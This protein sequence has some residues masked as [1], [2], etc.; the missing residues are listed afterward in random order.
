MRH[1]SVVILCEVTSLQMVCLFR[2]WIVGVLVEEMKKAVE[3]T[4]LDESVGAAE[5][6]LSIFH[7]ILTAL[8]R[9]FDPESIH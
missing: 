1:F 4:A 5:K 6:A 2:C 8:N 7:P 3:M 9:R